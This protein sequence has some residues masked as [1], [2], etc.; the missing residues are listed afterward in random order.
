MTPKILTLV[1]AAGLGL[2]A[3]PGTSTSQAPGGGCAGAACNVVITVDNC[4]PVPVPDPLSVRKA[5]GAVVI[6][7]RIAPASVAAGYTFTP[8]NGI[9]PH[10]DATRQFSGHASESPTHFHVNNANSNPGPTTYKYAIN[11]QRNGV[12]CPTKDPSII[13]G[14]N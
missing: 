7:W 14:A 2:A 10:D 1:V 12:A 4:D 3:Y 13:N 9:V 8:T 6:N 11:V 5:M